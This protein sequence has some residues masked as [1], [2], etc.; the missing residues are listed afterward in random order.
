VHKTSLTMTSRMELGDLPEAIGC[1]V[2]HGFIKQGLC[3]NASQ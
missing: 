1:A 2:G 3:H